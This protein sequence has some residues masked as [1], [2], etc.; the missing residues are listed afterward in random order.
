MG[1]SFYYVVTKNE[2]SSMFNVI[3]MAFKVRTVF[4]D[5]NFFIIFLS[6]VDLS[7]GGGGGA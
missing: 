7:W 5:V 6:V 1:H 4:F 3:F 2:I